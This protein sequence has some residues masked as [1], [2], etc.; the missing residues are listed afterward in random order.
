L[1][2]AKTEADRKRLTE[3]LDYG[4]DGKQCRRQTLLRL[5][6]YEGNGERPE[7]ECCDVCAG[8]TTT[9]L[10]EEPSLL[11]FFRRNP[12]AFTIG[13]AVHVLANAESINWS[14]EDAKQAINQLIRIGKL[15][16]IRNYLWKN[17]LTLS[18]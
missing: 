6:N 1:R 10:R 8:R 3:L 5:L 12:R 17:K 13:E 4:R 14:D 7:S 9:T 11:S 16:K 18:G 15:R 2:R